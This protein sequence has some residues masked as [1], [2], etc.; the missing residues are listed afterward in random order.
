MLGLGLGGVA[1]EALKRASILPCQL[2]LAWEASRDDGAPFAFVADT[3]EGGA[4][5][6][7]GAASVVDC[8]G[9]GGGKC[10]GTGG[11]GATL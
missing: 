8:V 9:T 2:S 10:L 6:G 11:D 1:F 7:G 3:V 5:D 4:S